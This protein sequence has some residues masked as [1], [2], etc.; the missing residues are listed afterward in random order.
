MSKLAEGF[1]SSYQ[2]KPPVDPEK[3]LYDFYFLVGH[4]S[5]S[6]FSQEEDQYSVAKAIEDCVNHL[7]KHMIAAL[8]FALSAEFRHYRSASD[9]SS[10]FVFKHEVAKMPPEMQKFLF[11]YEKETSYLQSKEIA[12]LDPHTRAIKKH[13]AQDPF[14]KDEQ[15]NSEGSSRTSHYVTAYKAILA[16][17]KATNTSEYELS[18]IFSY[19][20]NKLKWEG[21]YGGK[22]WANIADTY[23]KLITSTTLQDKIVW[24]DHAYDLQHNTD[25]VFNKLKNLYSKEGSFSWIARALDWKRDQTDLRKFYYKVSGSLRPLVGFIAYRNGVFIEDIKDETEPVPPSKSFSPSS[26]SPIPSSSSSSKFFIR[27]KYYKC[28]LTKRGPLWNSQG[29]MDG[30]LDGKPHKCIA[31]G[32]SV[33]Y[34][35]VDALFEGV[36]PNPVGD[37]LWSWDASEF[38][39]VPAPEGVEKTSVPESEFSVG[40]FVKVKSDVR[41]PK[42]GWGDV[43]S[44]QVGKIT[45]IHHAV[46]K[47]YVDFPVQKRWVAYL[48]EMEKVDDPLSKSK[49]K[50]TGESFKVGDTVKLNTKNPRS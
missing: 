50:K 34:D 20:F 32:D 46:Q 13:L 42:Y 33:S 49:K 11:K 23:R 31:V 1:I 45:S 39:E 15:E 44:T 14:L 47:A 38:E 43:S 48:P 19:I 6:K 27:G 41:K 17:Q 29:M 28:L 16:T 22:A 18:L 37:G 9:L 35:I 10:T 5:P 30:V 2:Y 12:V 40:D 25:T 4:A 21:G 8:K 26:P 7:Q 3:L 36:T 24:I